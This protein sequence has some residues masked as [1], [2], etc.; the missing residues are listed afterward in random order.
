MNLT[1][2][3]EAFDAVLDKGV[4]DAVLTSGKRPGRQAIREIARVLRRGTGRYVM[5][6]MSGPERRLKDLRYPNPSISY[7]PQPGE[8]PV[9]ECQVDE[10]K[11]Q[12]T[13]SHTYIC[14]T[15]SL[16]SEAEHGLKSSEL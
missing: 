3:D 10:V 1:F 9:F 2:L 8:T 12:Y 4:L 14:H 16:H 15:P 11:K 7:M 13:S 5:M 6:S